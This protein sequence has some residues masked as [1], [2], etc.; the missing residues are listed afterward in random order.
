MCACVETYLDAYVTI[1]VSWCELK[2]QIVSISA[3]RAAPCS[4][5]AQVTVATYWMLAGN[6]D[7]DIMD[8]VALFWY[9]WSCFCA[10]RHAEQ[11]EFCL[12]AILTL[13]TQACTRTHT[14]TRAV[15]YGLLSQPFL[16]KRLSEL[17]TNKTDRTRRWPE[18]RGAPVQPASSRMLNRRSQAGKACDCVGPPSSSRPGTA[19]LAL[20]H[21][22][23]ACR[24]RV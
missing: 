9:V 4:V 20:C 10:T 17:K 3:G 13:E 14:H 16:Q 2:A 11:L 18:T 1:S 19:T 6:I 21:R 8:C 22:N 12:T 15:C 7:N 24:C 5:C 23:P